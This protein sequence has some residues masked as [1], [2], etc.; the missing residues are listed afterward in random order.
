[1]FRT[2]WFSSVLLISACVTAPRYKAGD[3]IVPESAESQRHALKVA[4]VFEKK[5][6]LQRYRQLNGRQDVGEDFETMSIAKVDSEFAIT[7]CPMPINTNSEGDYLGAKRGHEYSQKQSDTLDVEKG[8]EWYRYGINDTLKIVHCCY[9]ESEI[10]HP[11]WVSDTR[12]QFVLAKTKE[13]E[14]GF[15]YILASRGNYLELKKLATNASGGNFRERFFITMADCELDR[16]N[17]LTSSDYTLGLTI[18]NAV[19]CQLR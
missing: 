19:L 11:H 15:N 18:D 9:K 2:F 7:E 6:K 4:A 10:T 13:S 12:K 3:C 16:K 8:Q 17:F 5:Y 1:M 14:A